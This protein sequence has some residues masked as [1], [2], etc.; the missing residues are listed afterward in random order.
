M[1]LLP[2]SVL[3]HIEFILLPLSLSKPTSTDGNI[4]GKT[5]I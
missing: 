1:I 3:L 5:V 4:L 2:P